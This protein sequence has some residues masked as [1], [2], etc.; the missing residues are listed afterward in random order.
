MREHMEAITVNV[1]VYFPLV[2]LY[3]YFSSITITN[4][5]IYCIQ[6]YILT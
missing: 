3:A 5:Y 1:L 6:F 2:F 4:H